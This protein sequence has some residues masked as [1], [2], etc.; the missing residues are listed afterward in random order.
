MHS[1]P[2]LQLA[3]PGHTYCHW[4][5]GITE[6]CLPL[7]PAPTDALAF[8]QHANMAPSK[9]NTLY[10]SHSHSQW[11]AT[12]KHKGAGSSGGSGSSSTDDGRSGGSRG[13]GSGGSSM[14]ALQPQSAESVVEAAASF[15]AAGVPALFLGALPDIRDSSLMDFLPQAYSACW[16]L[17]PLAYF[18]YS[19]PMKRGLRA[20]QHGQAEA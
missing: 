14:A 8:L 3:H 10:H 20:Q 7:F 12:S 11:V 19:A 18:E 4:I 17:W 15:L 16:L 5:R 6:S 9:A 13:R 2:Y 1:P